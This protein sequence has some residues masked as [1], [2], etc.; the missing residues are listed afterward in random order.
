MSAPGP[1]LILGL[2]VSGV[3]AAQLAAALGD[4]VI[5]L[6]TGDSPGLRERTGTLAAAGVDVRLGWTAEQWPG[7]A[8]QQAVTVSYTHLTLPT[9]RE[10]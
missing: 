8:P 5:G 2:G 7:S 10:V 3:A 9:N 6:D 4:P 1:T